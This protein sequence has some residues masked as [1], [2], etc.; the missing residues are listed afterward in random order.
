Y[1]SSVWPSEGGGYVVP[2]LTIPVGYCRQNNRCCRSSPKASA[3]P[4]R[5]LRVALESLNYDSPPT[6]H[7]AESSP[8][9]RESGD[10]ARSPHQ[11]SKN[12]MS[13][14]TQRQDRS[15][16]TPTIGVAP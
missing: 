5:R 8:L 15:G 14:D 3:Q 6:S 11:R 1:S 4:H 9:I 2:G 16:D 10:P 12:E 13:A 7:A